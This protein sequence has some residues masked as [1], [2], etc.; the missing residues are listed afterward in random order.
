MVA[1]VDIAYTVR[2]TAPDHPAFHLPR[3]SSDEGARGG[4]D[5]DR[6]V[7]VAPRRRSLDHAQSHRDQSADPAPL[8]SPRGLINV[9][10]DV[11]VTTNQ[12]VAA[13]AQLDPS[14]VWRPIRAGRLRSISWVE[15]CRRG[16]LNCRTLPEPA[17][18]HRS[19]WARRKLGYQQLVLPG[20]QRLRDAGRVGGP[21]QPH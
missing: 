6:A 3:A 5:H 21:R 15:V 2:D 16:N 18:G 20:P 9:V 1:S 10:N 13:A 4:R 19:A 14:D 8:A 17:G 11:I 7:R 12:A